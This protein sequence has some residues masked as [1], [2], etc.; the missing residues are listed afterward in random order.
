MTT[1]RLYYT[2][3]YTTAFEATVIER[4][5]EN[6]TPAVALDRS[7]F[8][9]TSGG[10]PHDTGKL[11]GVPVID[12]VV[13]EADGAVLHLLGS[14]LDLERV[15][16]QVDWDRRFDHMQH[17]TGQHILSQAFI[18]VADAETVG[19]HLSPDS[20]TIDLDKGHIT[21]AMV[22]EAEALANRIVTGNHPVR[23]VFPTADEVAALPL[24]KVPDVD[25]K[26]RVVDIDGF[27]VTA[28]GG[29][30]VAQTG[31]VGLIKVL[32]VDKRGDGVR[33]EFRCG[34]RALRD[35]REKHAILSQL[36]AEL[37]TGYWEIPAALD[38]L[39]EQ[40]KSLQRDLRA[41]RSGLLDGEAETLWNQADRSAGYALVVR[42]F[43]GYDAGEVRQVV[44]KLIGHERTIALCGVAGDKAMLI[45][46]RSEDLPH[47]M[48][49]VLMRG[50]ATW[51]VERGGGR[52]SFAQGGGVAA[53]LAQVDA[54][55]AAARDAVRSVG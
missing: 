35:Y 21:P 50:L 16:G 51:G 6:G 4:T 45:V 12:V 19:F 28:C 8:Y 24:R 54:A 46:A 48:V 30:H 9:P 3:S 26:L 31:A 43:E 34:G 37:T 18:R 7:F 13:R 47:D 2:D 33:V 44:Q 5:T 10:Q 41:L 25:G 17:H 11:D 32:R 29:T 15:T 42:S 14:A 27:D 49:P 52:P 20:V 40:N 23:V 39:R 38:R 36:A 1:Q 53:S 55:L 22:D